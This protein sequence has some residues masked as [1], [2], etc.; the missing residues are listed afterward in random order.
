MSQLAKAGIRIKLT[1]VAPQQA[2]QL[3]MIEGKGSMHISPAGGFPDPTQFYE[4][5]FGKEALRNAGKIELPGY[6]E[7][8]DASMSAPDQTTRKKVF[9]ELQKFVAENAMELVQYISQG[10][11]VRSPKVHNYVDGLLTTPKFHELWI[12]A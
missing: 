8:I 2:M 1:P 6:R 4:A 9:A 11:I 10:V 7:L 3:F 5:L 12:E